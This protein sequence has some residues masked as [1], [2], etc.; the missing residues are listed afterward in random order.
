MPGELR[1]FQYISENY[2]RL[3]WAQLFAPSINLAE[4]GFTINHDMYQWFSG[5]SFLYNDSAWSQDFAPNGTLLGL[6]D[7]LTRKRYAKTLQTIADCGADAFY[8]GYIAE[9]TIAAVQAHNGTLV[10]ADLNDYKVKIRPTIEITYRGY[11]ITSCTAPSSGAVVLSA[12]KLVEGYPFIGDPTQ[13]NL[14][15]HL[16]DEAWKFGYGQV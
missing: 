1:G 10:V 11:K 2:G 8:N 12:M 9:T 13:K 14:S 15:T 4:N 7:T 5:Y 16:V 3:P 6:G